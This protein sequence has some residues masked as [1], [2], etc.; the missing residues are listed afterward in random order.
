MARLPRL[1]DGQVIGTVKSLRYNLNYT[2]SIRGSNTGEVPE[3]QYLDRQLVCLA[4]GPVGQSIKA[5]KNPRELVTTIRDI[6][7]AIRD[8]FQVDIVH[9]DISE[10]VR[11]TGASVMIQSSLA[12]LKEKV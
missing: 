7:L 5:A 8:L 9:H 4:V 3:S 1:L 2:G 11:P 6:A 10:Q 12:N